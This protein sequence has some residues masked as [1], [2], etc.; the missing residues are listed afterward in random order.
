M[1]N[2]LLSSILLSIFL[3]MLEKG[4]MSVRGLGVIGVSI[5]ICLLLGLAARGFLGFL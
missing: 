2:L 4:L 5:G 1:Y 3:R